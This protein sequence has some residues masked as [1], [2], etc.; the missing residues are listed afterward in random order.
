[1]R[2]GR[3]Q[4][5]TQK[6]NSNTMK[7]TKL[8]KISVFCSTIIF[9]L[10]VVKAEDRIPEILKRITLAESNGREKDCVLLLRDIATAKDADLS[11]FGGGLGPTTRDSL[12]FSAVLTLWPKIMGSSIEHLPSDPAWLRI[13]LGSQIDDESLKLALASREPVTRLAAILKSRQRVNLSES[14]I[15][16]LKRIASADQYLQIQRR[17]I[18]SGEGRPPLPGQT[19]NIIVAPL[20]QLA[21]RELMARGLPETAK[22]Q[23]DDNEAS[24]WISELNEIEGVSAEDIRFALAQLTAEGPRLKQM[25]EAAVEKNAAKLEQLV[26]QYREHKSDETQ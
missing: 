22:L 7:T 14:A 12:L 1:M 24:R 16:S 21:E 26:Q 6:L 11:S 2:I 20:R 19:E 15:A 5:K 9:F 18:A 23:P 8:I 17:P 13:L 25:K 3:I 4:E 10:Q